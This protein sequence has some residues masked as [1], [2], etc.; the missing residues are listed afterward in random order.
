ML[1][2]PEYDPKTPS[3]SDFPTSQNGSHPHAHAHAIPEVPR[4]SPGGRGRGNASRGMFSA[5]QRNRAEFSQAG[6]N[7]DRTRTTVVVEQ[8]PEESFSEPAVRDFFGAFGTIEEVTM[9]P[10]K[11]LALVKYSDYNSAKQAYESPKVIFDN[12]FVKVFWYKPETSSQGLNGSSDST[13]SQPPPS[14]PE[15]PAFDRE[16]FARTAEAAQKKLEERKAAIL[17]IEAKKAELE[18]QKAEL[19]LKQAE[20]KRRLEDK[21]KAKGISLSD[22]SSATA[23]PLPAT[24]GAPANP[25]AAAQTEVLRASLRALEEEAKS[26]GLDP[27]PWT[28]QPDDG[29]SPSAGWG[30]GRGRASY[31]GA[32]GGYRARGS[33]RG[34]ARGGGTAAFNLDNRPRTVKVEGVAFDAAAD[35]SLR[36]HLLVSGSSPLPLTRFCAACDSTTVT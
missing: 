12:R 21:L 35:E 13:S 3:I 30:R 6:P 18:K 33:F 7:H 31:R 4:A 19:A 17:V 22:T 34:G 36:Q 10:Y 28:K 32:W 9:Q 23:P 11:R 14:K 25:K 1:S 16:E 15:E 29:S 24:N 2:R 26:L 20:E 5:R 27:E 8:I